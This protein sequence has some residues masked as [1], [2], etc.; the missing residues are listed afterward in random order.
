MPTPMMAPATTIVASQAPSSRRRPAAPAGAAAVR[1]ALTARVR[2]RSGSAPPAVPPRARARR[3]CPLGLVSL[4][5]EP[6]ARLVLRQAACR[7][8]RDSPLRLGLD[9]DHEVEVGREARFDELGRLEHHDALGR[10]R[11][12]A[13]AAAH[14]RV[15]R[16][17][18]PL[19]RRGIGEDAAGDRRGI[20][21]AVVA[22]ELW[23]EERAHGLGAGAAGA[24]QLAHQLV[25]VDDREAGAAQVPGDGRLAARQPAGQ[26]DPQP[27]HRRPRL[28]PA[29]A[30][31][32]G[33]AP[34]RRR[35]RSASPP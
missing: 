8:P 6:A 32:A 13:E 30:R 33:A 21:A 22:Q 11:D 18:E 31:R 14:E 5:R 29:P 1:T 10:P 19:A 28:R 9:G 35:W 24:V 4:R 7:R 23:S 15:E 20:G 2:S 34:P 3:G 17:L 16:P 27:R 12:L 25:G 26:P